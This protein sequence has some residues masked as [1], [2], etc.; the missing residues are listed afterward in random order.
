MESVGKRQSR[1]VH[2]GSV[3]TYLSV[4]TRDFLA[5]ELTHVMCNGEDI[6]ASTR[7]T[8]DLF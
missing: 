4:S 3:A 8:I 7:S 5:S 2:R 6:E 1:K